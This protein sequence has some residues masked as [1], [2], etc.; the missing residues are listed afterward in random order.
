[1]SVHACLPACGLQNP[2]EAGHQL[3]PHQ[4]ACS[5]ARPSCRGGTSPTMQFFKSSLILLF[6]SRVVLHRGGDLGLA[7][8]SAPVVSEEDLQEE[9]KLPLQ[10]PPAPP[11]C[12]TPLT[13]SGNRSVQTCRSLA[14]PLVCA[15]G[16]P[17]W[18]AS[19]SCRRLSHFR[20]E[21]VVSPCAS[22]KALVPVYGSG[23]SMG[24]AGGGEGWCPVSGSS[25][26]S[27]GGTSNTLSV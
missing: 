15:L 8:G 25:S 2:R 17:S 9:A 4:R 23:S 16:K 27:L 5:A 22:E 24:E 13:I 11:S 7:Q 21:I 1:M 6:A 18:P 20:F 19:L 26:A 10:P 12:P 14:D 3:I